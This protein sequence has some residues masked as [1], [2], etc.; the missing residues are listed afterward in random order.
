MA[1]RAVKLPPTETDKKPQ[2]ERY[3]WRECRCRACGKL[4][5]RAIITDGAKIE[6]RCQRCGHMAV[7]PM[8][9]AEKQEAAK[10]APLV[11]FSTA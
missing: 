6:I 1:R 7:F 2:P 5:C 11:E 9:E 4:L 8:P 3:I 10:V